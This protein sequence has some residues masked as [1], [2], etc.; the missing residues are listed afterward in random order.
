M[1]FMF[2]MFRYKIEQLADQ[3]LII[4]DLQFSVCFESDDCQPVVTICK[5]Q[6]LPMPLCGMK[7]DFR[8]DN[9]S[10]AVWMKDRGLTVKQS[11]TTALG[12]DLLDSFGLTNYMNDEQC[13][14][15]DGIYAGAVNGWNQKGFSLKRFKIEYNIQGIATGLNL[16]RLLEESGIARHLKDNQ[17]NRLTWPFAFANSS[18]WNDGK[19]LQF[20]LVG[21]FNIK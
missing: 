9:V 11:L 12:I 5:S 2:V 6:L 3:R 19:L 1:A 18:G 21:V 17:C 7:M 8:E 4:L 16:A 14:R 20:N 13:S 15:F 10:L